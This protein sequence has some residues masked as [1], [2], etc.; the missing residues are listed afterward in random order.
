M[1]GCWWSPVKGFRC[2]GFFFVAARALIGHTPG[3]LGMYCKYLFVSK[4]SC[5]TVWV[6]HGNLLHSV[7]EHG[8]FLNIIY[9]RTCIATH[10]KYGGI[11]DYHF[12]ENLLLCLGL[13]E[14][15]KSVER[16]DGVT[17]RS[18]VS[19][20]LGTQCS[21]CCMLNVMSLDGSLEKETRKP[22]LEVASTTLVTF[23]CLW[24]WTLP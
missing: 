2:D 14:F 3:L 7:L 21:V 12:T 18:L 8:D 19:S 13:K 6:T 16:F 17:T 23:S 9:F 24:A 5:V 22:S 15:W 20:F 4:R 11:F 1:T 10:L